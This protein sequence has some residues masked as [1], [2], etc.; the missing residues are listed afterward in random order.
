[1]ALLAR[2][3]TDAVQYALVKAHNDTRR[4]LAVQGSF[5]HA[6]V[7]SVEG[8][9]FT[10]P[11]ATALAVAHATATDHNTAADMAA[12]FATKF[13][14]HL[15]DTLAHKVADTT[16]KVTAA[17]P[18]H[19]TSEADLATFVTALKAKFDTHIASTTYHYTADT[20][21]SASGVSDATDDA[22]SV[23]LINALKTKF[24]AH[25]LGA[26]AGY[27]VDLVSP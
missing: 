18:T 25:V 15:A 14:L 1:M 23:T 6:D 24:N 17:L 11:S 2:K 8:G 20:A 21:N 3:G 7:T 22:S 13:N 16:D 12:E 10:S 19:A 5:F 9:D 26:P 4:E 27:S